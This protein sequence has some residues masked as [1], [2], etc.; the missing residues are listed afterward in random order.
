MK[1]TEEEKTNKV[2]FPPFAERTPE[3]VAARTTIAEMNQKKIDM[4]AIVSQL[5]HDITSTLISIN[6]YIGEASVKLSE[7]QQKGMVEGIKAD[8]VAQI[9][10]WLQAA[11][12]RLDLYDEAVDELL[13]IT[14]W[15]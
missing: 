1:S 15:N 12:E 10:E 13:E 9:K 7:L 5:D 4:Q 14:G 6:N 3:L 8:M 11:I 2:W